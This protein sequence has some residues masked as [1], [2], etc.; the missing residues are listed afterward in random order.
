MD[1][2][3]YHWK[4]ILQDNEDLYLKL[5]GLWTPEQ[6]RPALQKDFQNYVDKQAKLINSLKVKNSTTSKGSK[7]SKTPAEK[8]CWDC[9]KKGEVKGHEGCKTPGTNK[10][11]PAKSKKEDKLHYF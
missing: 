1:P 2:N 5:K 10:F 8:K 9:G 3:K 7:T 11:K 6:S 4:Q